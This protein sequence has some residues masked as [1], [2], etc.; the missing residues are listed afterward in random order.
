M[1]CWVI[2]EPPWSCSASPCR[3]WILC[4][5]ALMRELKRI[6]G[7]DRKVSSSVATIAWI[8][9]GEISSKSS[10]LLSSSKNLN[11]SLP[12]L[13]K[14]TLDWGV[15]MTACGSSGRW[16]TSSHPKNRYPHQR[17]PIVRRT[18]NKNVFMPSNSKRQYIIHIPY[19]YYI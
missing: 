6:P 14:M 16:W 15:W 8:I 19:I 2:V 11:S 3:T 9:S 5:V 1:S 13:S 10:C 18:I 17:Q 4:S 12:C 7:F